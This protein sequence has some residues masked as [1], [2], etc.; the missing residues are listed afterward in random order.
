VQVRLSLTAHVSKNIWYVPRTQTGQDV[1]TEYLP[2]SPYG[3][4][5][6]N[7]K[8]SECYNATI[9][10]TDKSNYRKIVSCKQKI[11]LTKKRYSAMMID[12]SGQSVRFL[13]VSGFNKL[14]FYTPFLLLYKVV[15]F[16]KPHGFSSFRPYYITDTAIYQPLFG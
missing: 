11:L 12:G 15:R 6:K 1:G 16:L 10:V 14:T 2:G 5:F 8:K 3:I 7:N 9:I 13:S 4:E